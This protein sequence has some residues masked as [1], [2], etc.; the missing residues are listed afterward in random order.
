MQ[1]ITLNTV[2]AIHLIK[3]RDIIYCKSKNSYTTFYL[4]NHSPITVSQSI[5]EIEQK[6]SESSF[7]RPH[8]SYLVNPI[9][10]VKVNK[11]NNYSIL[12][13]DNSIIPTSTRKRKKI[14]QILLKN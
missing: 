8:Q 6:L 2:D 10:A 11:T 12:L 7:I 9:H 4:T 1:R 3:V 5:K 14:L 13:S